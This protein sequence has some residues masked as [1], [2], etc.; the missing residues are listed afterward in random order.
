M[1][2]G[3]TKRVLIVGGGISG[4]SA[5]WF[6]HRRGIDIRLL[7]G[8]ARLGGVIDTDRRNDFAVELGPNTIL[9]KPG[10][11]EDSLGRLL[12]ETGLS[13][14]VQEA[15]PA[16]KKRFILRDGHVCALPTSPPAFL[17][18][19]TFSW[20]AKL[21]LLCEPFI[22]RS[23]EEET[24]ARFVTRRLGR[25]FL[26]YAIDPFISGV[27]AGDTRALS[28]QAAVPRIYEIE[29]RYGSLIRGAVAMGKAAKGAGNPQGRQI[30]FTGGMAALPAGI[31][32]K[33]PA[34]SI[35]TR[36]RVQALH[37]R[38]GGWQIHLDDPDGG[39]TET[40]DAVIL[41]LPA[42]EA[43]ELVRP[44][45]PRAVDTLSAIPYVSI[46][47]AGLGYRRDQIAHALDGFGCLVPRVEGVRTLGVLFSSTLFAESAPEG[48]VL[49]TAFIGGAHDP[50]AAELADDEL[51]DRLH[52]DLAHTLGI[53]GTPVYR[54][55]TR[56]NRA[57]PQYTL[58]HLDRIA[59][60]DRQLEPLPG[61]FL[62]GSWRGGISVADCIRSGETLARNIAESFD[63]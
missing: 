56:R 15:T 34:G 47:S 7:E 60:I 38:D 30:S 39:A 57:I 42:R 53:G 10:R 52:A 27:Y 2:A 26:D 28:V 35:R 61:L 12:D 54:R 17:A 59:E 1:T 18:T 50:D 51:S 4:L 8:A 45:A 5:A 49:L 14:R 31:A 43:A 33:L 9:Q 3:S 29:Q 40:A 63:D 36:A 62:R 16:G 6:L 46:V 41:A 48:H 23:S 21:R 55:I 13:V 44:L 22:G 20:P 24:I 25:E 58:G 37:P 11:P 19:R 32:E